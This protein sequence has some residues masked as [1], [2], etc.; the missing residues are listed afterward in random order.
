MRA[1][2]E[3]GDSG[4]SVSAKLQDWHAVGRFGFL[5]RTTDYNPHLRLRGLTKDEA[6][7]L[8]DQ[9][10]RLPANPVRQATIIRFPPQLRLIDGGIA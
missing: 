8:A 2:I 5:P 3:L 4:F 7:R 1:Y 9:I 10:N 6:D